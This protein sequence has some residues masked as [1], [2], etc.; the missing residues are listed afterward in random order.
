MRFFVGQ[1]PGGTRAQGLRFSRPQ[2][3]HCKGNDLFP[4]DV[5]RGLDECF[6]RQEVCQL[7][8]FHYGFAL[9]PVVAAVAGTGI[10]AGIA[11]A[12]PRAELASL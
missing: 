7:F 12:N 5:I 9:G 4:Q 2:V 8:Y 11:A 3:I 1:R 6:R 10:L